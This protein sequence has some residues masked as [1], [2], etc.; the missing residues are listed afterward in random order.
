MVQIIFSDLFRE[1][2]EKLD[3]TP[4]QVSGER[5]TQFIRRDSRTEL[6]NGAPICKL[7][8]CQNLSIIDGR[9]LLRYSE[10]RRERSRGKKPASPPAPANAPYWHLD[11]ARAEHTIANAWRWVHVRRW[12]SAT[13][14]AA[15]CRTPESGVSQWDRAKLAFVNTAHVLPR[16]Y[17]RH[18]SQSPTPHS[19][20]CLD[21]LAWFLAWRPSERW[22]P[23]PNPGLRNSRSTDGTPTPRRWSPKCRLTTLT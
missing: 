3:T 2:S 6:C 20:S 17:T 21:F 16:K 23:R 5:V 14:P 1:N 7:Q 4:R 12:R 11:A 15:S 8:P 9:A 19:S 13:L 22:P 10:A 18:F